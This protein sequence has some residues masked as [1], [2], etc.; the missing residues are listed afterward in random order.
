MDELG[1]EDLPGGSGWLADPDVRPTVLVIGGF[2]TS[3]PTYA[4]F[5]RRL[6]ARGAAHVE[7]ANVWT[8]DW[9]LAARRGLGPVA[10]RCARAVLH[11]SATAAASSAS[12]GAPL[13]VVGHSAGGVMARVLTAREPFQGR[14]VAAAERFGA[15][16][17]LGTPHLV[18]GGGIRNEAGGA[19][20]AFIGEHVPGAFFSPRVGYLTVASRHVVGRPDGDRRSR[21]AYGL[22]QGLRPEPGAPAIEGDGLIPVRSALVEGTRQL[23]LDDAI[24]GQGMREPWYGSDGIIDRW[25][26]IALEVWRVALDARRDAAGLRR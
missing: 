21:T 22:Y 14:R 8:P 25:W 13:L 24:H 12:R 9:I 16:V 23:L 15:I 26:P 3:P 17:T 2:I 18:T 19:A 20:A 4:A 6:L 5:R 11:A 10:T 7:V 1:R